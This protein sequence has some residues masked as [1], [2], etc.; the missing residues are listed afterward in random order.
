MLYEVIT[1]MVRSTRSYAAFSLLQGKTTEFAL[2][3]LA[4]EAELALTLPT[5]SPAKIY[6]AADFDDPSSAPEDIV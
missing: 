5:P 1:E 6:Y 4:A 2:R 3:W